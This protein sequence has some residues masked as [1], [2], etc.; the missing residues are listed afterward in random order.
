M[1]AEFGGREF[2]LDSRSITAA[3]DCGVRGLWLAQRPPYGFDSAGRRFPM[4]A[5]SVFREVLIRR[6]QAGG[7][8]FAETGGQLPLTKWDRTTPD[9]ESL[10]R[11]LDQWCEALGASRLGESFT[12]FEFNVKVTSPETD[13]TAKLDW[14]DEEFRQV[15]LL[16]VAKHDPEQRVRLE[17]ALVSDIIE[18]LYGNR[19]K[20]H[21][22]WVTRWFP[23]SAN[24]GNH[25]A[26]RT[27]DS[28][29][30]GTAED[31]GAYEI[32]ERLA[33]QEQLY[34][35]P[36]SQQCLRCVAKQDCPI[37]GDA[38]DADHRATN[39]TYLEGDKSW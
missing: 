2:T 24:A 11:E 6:L 31:W 3:A 1:S 7:V 37:F 18:D 29:A 39:T 15:I 21:L 10:D 9:Q 8:P 12:R 16:K 4:A 28:P 22:I 19:P 27:Y 32:A 30:A 23:S 33:K 25:P 13:V 17:M 5:V 20:F 36:T 14:A 34:P 26:I 35:N 38:A